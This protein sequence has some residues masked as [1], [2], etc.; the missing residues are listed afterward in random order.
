MYVSLFQVTSF[1]RDSQPQLNICTERPFY[2]LHALPISSYSSDHPTNFH[3]EHKLV[4]LVTFRSPPA[5]GLS[6]S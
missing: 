4:A 6:P 1:L 5:S 3:N 2:V